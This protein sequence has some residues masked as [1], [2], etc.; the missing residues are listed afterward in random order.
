VA[1]GARQRDFT[2]HRLDHDQPAAGVH[3]EPIGGAGSVQR[4]TGD[5]I[6]HCHLY[7]HF[8][9]GMWGMWRVFDVAQ[10]GTGHYPDGTPIA[11]LQPLPGHEPPPAPTSQRPGFPGFIAGRFP[12]RSPRPPRTPLMPEGMGREPTELERAAF[13][14][15]PQPGEAFTKVTLDSNAPLRRYDLMVVTGTVRYY[16]S[17]HTS[18]HDHRCVFYVTAQ[19]VDEAGGIEAFQAQLADGSRQVAP[20]AIRAAKGE[21]VELSLTNTLP[22]GC[23][24]QTAFDPVLPFQ[25]ECGLHVHLVKFDPLVSDGSSVGWNYLSGA[26][27]PDAG[28]TE[29]AR[30]H[31][32]I[33]RWYCD[34]DFGTIFYHDHLLANERQRHGLFGCLVAEPEGAEWVDPADHGR[35]AE[36]ICVN[37]DDRYTCEPFGS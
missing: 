25:P 34:E 23:H 29:H 1:G 24:E 5:I 20:I 6:W 7:P 2:D 22:P 30:Y 28:P 14:D 33:Y 9:A 12:Q 32:W 26:T 35:E 36:G 37:T 10:D 13:C 11:A 31:T 18:W 17:E 4:A 21:I 27:T 19:E 16:R 15:D 8:H 3:D